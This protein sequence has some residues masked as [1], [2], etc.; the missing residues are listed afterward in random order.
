MAV[1]QSP[2]APPTPAPTSKRRRARGT[3][4]VWGVCVLVHCV[5]EFNCKREWISIFIKALDTNRYKR[6]A[7]GEHGLRRQR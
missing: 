5:C 1:C 7:G 3:R 4:P 6:H 2:V